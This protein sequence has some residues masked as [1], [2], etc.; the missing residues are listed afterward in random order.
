GIYEAIQ[1]TI[2]EAMKARDERTLAF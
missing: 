1:A 2:K